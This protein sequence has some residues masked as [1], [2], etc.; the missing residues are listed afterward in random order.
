LTFLFHIKSNFASDVIQSILLLITFSFFL[1]NHNDFSRSKVMNNERTI[2]I[3]AVRRKN[4]NKHKFVF[5]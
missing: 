5:K 1:K 2:G 3:K 4:S